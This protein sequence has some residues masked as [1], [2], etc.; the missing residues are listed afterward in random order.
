MKADNTQQARRFIAVLGAFLIGAFILSLAGTVHFSSL[1]FDLSSPEAVAAST[2]EVIGVAPASFAD[3][4][5]HL[6]PAV[7]N[8]STTKTIAAGGY[9]SPFNDP[10]FE[11]FFGGDEF[12][13]RFFGDMPEREYKQRS[14]G[15]GFIISEDG[16]I[17]T[18]NHVVEKAD[19]IVVKLSSGKEYKA[20]IKGKDQNTDIAL[21]K[22]E[23]DNGLPVAK[24]GDSSKLRVGDWVIAIG[25]PFGLSE[26]VTAG[27]VSAKGRVIGA[28]PYDDFIQTDASINPG[29]SGGPLFNLQGEVVGINTAIVAQGQGIGFAIPVDMAKDILPN[30]KAKGK[31]TRGWLGV[32]VQGITEDIAQNLKLETE[33]GALVS[34]V[35]AG[36]PADKAGIKTGDV[37]IKIDGNDIQDTHELIKI[38]AGIAVGEKVKIMVIRD[39]KR[40]IFT[41]TV[42]ERPESGDIARETSDEKSEE[43]LG[44]TVQAITPEIAEHLGLTDPSG[45]VIAQVESGSPADEAGLQGGDIVIQINRSRISSLED[46]RDVMSRVVSSDSVLLL[47]QREK[48]KFFA[49]VRK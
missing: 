19:E 35:F 44:M 42:T 29:N 18:N 33:K 49:V 39:G 48:S 9:R 17:F 12:F 2:T 27:I 43:H 8:I 6:R 32:S 21:L 45:V 37:I 40:K 3:L 41:V 22:I 16:Y 25:N 11:R 20:T 5:E 10:R 34:D 36:D 7:V 13:K 15:S 26:T 24:L 4:A 31:V 23:P 47:I 30:L 46:Y 1:S 38:V 14:L 28:G